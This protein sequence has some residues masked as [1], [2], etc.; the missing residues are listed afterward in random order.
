MRESGKKLNS[1]RSFVIQGFYLLPCMPCCL[2]KQSR[3]VNIKKRFHLYTLEWFCANQEKKWT[4]NCWNICHVICIPLS[5]GYSIKLG[6]L[7]VI[8]RNLLP[9]P[10][11]EKKQHIFAVQIS[12]ILNKQKMNYENTALLNVVHRIKRNILNRVLMDA[13]CH[14]KIYSLLNPAKAC[15]YLSR[16]DEHQFGVSVC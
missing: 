4:W 3:E 16:N 14:W 7:L 1:V 2:W 5:T 6:G 12:S 9:Q 15:A 8:Q 10:A 11:Q 13:I